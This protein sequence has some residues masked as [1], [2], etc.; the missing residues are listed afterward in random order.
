MQRPQNIQDFFTTILDVYKIANQGLESVT[1]DDFM[2]FVEASYT[3]KSI[4]DIQ[5]FLKSLDL[6]EYIR[7][8]I[9]ETKLPNHPELECNPE[10][11]SADPKLQISSVVH[12]YIAYFMQS[13]VQANDNSNTSHNP[14]STKVN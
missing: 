10:I 14:L 8:A 5:N 3:Q 4:Q 11:E 1:T 12:R 13:S 6:R 9:F 7:F 2:G